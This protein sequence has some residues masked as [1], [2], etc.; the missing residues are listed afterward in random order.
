MRIALLGTR[1]LPA[2]YSGFETLVEA[3]GQRLAARG[4]DVTVYCRPHMVS[5]RYATY[6]GMRL[7]YL[8]TITNKYLDTIVHT[9]MCTVHM[10]VRRRP[11][12]A[13]YFIAGNSPLAALSRLLGIPSII[14]VDGLDSRR[15]K[16]NRYARLYLRWA[17]RNAPRFANATITDSRA[18]QK[19]YR[20]EYGAETHFIP[21]GSELDGEDTGEHLRRFGLEARELHPLRR[22]PR[23][24]EQRPRA[25]RGLRGAGHRPQARGGRRRSVLGRVPRSRCMRPRTSASCSP[26]TSIGDGYRELI[27]NAALFVA[28]TEVGSTHPVIVEAMAAGNCVVVN[29]YEPNLETIGDAGLSYPGHEG[30]AGL[31]R[32]LAE[33]LDDPERVE[34]YRD[35]GARAR[36]DGVLVGRCERRPTRGW[37]RTSLTDARTGTTP[38]RS[39]DS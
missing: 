9:L 14:N 6:K 39:S 11:D 15:A 36:A 31:R 1:G 17:E 26:A 4:H 21:Y 28:P 18:V 16:W 32:V 3:V 38:Q 19:L 22:S 23:A 8:P 34:R 13:V 2:A 10:A 25:R 20:D 29:D 12:V 33:L 24:R 27:R 30:A 5:G 37:R 7:V 35:S